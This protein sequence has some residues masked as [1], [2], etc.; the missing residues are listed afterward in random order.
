MLSLDQIGLDFGGRTLFEEVALRVNQG[1]RIGLVGRNG[2]GKSTLLRI[3]AAQQTPTKGVVSKQKNLKIGYFN[4]DLL[5]YESDR[6]LFEVVAQAFGSAYDYLLELDAL[7]NKGTDF[8]EKET[9][10]MYYLQ[11]EVQ[12]LDAYRIES[13]VKKTLVGLGFTDVEMEKTYRLFS[14]GW[15]MRAMLAKCLL[16]RPDLLMLDEPTNHLDLPAIQWLEQFIARYEGAVM[17]VSH[18]KA[19]LD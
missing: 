13:E 3:I 10:R 14:G 6:S 8:T 7:Y 2:M 16:E 19:I 11:E 15:R 12:R 4:Q 17:I 5:A 18:D 1:D 9:D